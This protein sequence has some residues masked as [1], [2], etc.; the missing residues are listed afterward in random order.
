MPMGSRRE[1]VLPTF[2]RREGVTLAEKPEPAKPCLCLTRLTC[3]KCDGERRR[4]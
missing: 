1:G 2:D 3:P 4:R